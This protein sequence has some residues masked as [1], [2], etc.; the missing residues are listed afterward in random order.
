MSSISRQYELITGGDFNYWR[1]ETSKTLDNGDTEISYDWNELERM[2]QD[3]LIK[4]LLNYTKEN[5]GIEPYLYKWFLQN[6]YV[7]ET[8]EVKVDESNKDTQMMEIMKQW[9]ESSEGG[10]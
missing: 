10:R 6:G 3:G 2:L 8:I 1:A 7:N 9:A 5:E 4:Y